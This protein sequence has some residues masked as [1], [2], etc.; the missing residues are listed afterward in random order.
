MQSVWLEMVSTFAGPSHTMSQLLIGNMGHRTASRASFTTYRRDHAQAGKPQT[1]YGRIRLY[2]GS[3]MTYRIDLTPEKQ[4][5]IEAA[6]ARLGV[7]VETF[8]TQAAESQAEKGCHRTQRALRRARFARHAGADIVRRH[9]HRRAG[10]CGSRTRYAA[11]AKVWEMPTIEAVL[12]ASGVAAFALPDEKHHGGAQVCIVALAWQSARLIAP[13]LWESKTDSILR[14]RVYLGTLTVQAA[15]AALRVL[16][17]LQV[18]I[19][20]HAGTRVLARTIGEQLNQVRVYDAT[21]AALAQQRGCALW[22]A[23]E[24][25]YNSATNQ[26][27]G[28]EHC[29]S[30][31]LLEHK[32]RRDNRAV[33]EYGRN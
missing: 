23:D 28:A 13:P 19:V 5:R 2:S 20:Y 7:A 26:G 15:I 21:Y 29:R 14:R 8:I 27:A 18:E 9:G 17:A 24:R 1:E 3:L 6:A 16:D 12:D 32:R 31:V 4:E 25:F 30:S 10:G 22:T 33:R 11:C